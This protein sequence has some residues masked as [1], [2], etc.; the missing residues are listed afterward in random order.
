MIDI[1][2]PLWAH[3]K[4]LWLDFEKAG[5]AILVAGGYGLFLKQQW[6]LESDTE[7]I[8]IPLEGWQDAVPR[9]TKDMDL[10]VSLDLISDTSANRQLFDALEKQEFQV[11][12]TAHGKRWQFFKEIGDDQH[13]IVELHTPLPEKNIESLQANRFAVKHKPSLGD[14]GVHG[15]TNQEAIGSEVHPFQFQLE[16]VSVVV[17]NPVTWSIMKLTAAEDTWS[18]SLDPQKD[19][20]QRGFLRRQA[21]KHGNDVCR[22]IAMMTLDERDLSQQIVE[23]LKG[24]PPFERAAMAYR[25]FFTGEDDW[26]T[27]IL[28][29]NWAT[30]DLETIHTVLRS[31]YDPS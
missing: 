9:A 3:F 24:K 15:R 6:L 17:P 20:E 21:I 23:A 2:D 7:R 4:P 28:A 31:W 19:S 29:D 26:A 13:V 30:E 18:R 12:K 16:G 5:G 22:A 1:D 10:V 14:R 27:E 8:V 25:D 11:S